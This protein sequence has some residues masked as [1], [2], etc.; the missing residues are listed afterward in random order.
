MI[1]YFTLVASARIV[2][3]LNGEVTGIAADT[4]E[5]TFGNC[6]RNCKP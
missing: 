2:N 3:D 6:V 1:H 4:M 5:D